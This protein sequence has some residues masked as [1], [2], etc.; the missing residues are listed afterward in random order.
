MNILYEEERGRERESERKKIVKVF[1]FRNAL[2]KEAKDL[3]QVL[4]SVGFVY[5]TMFL[6]P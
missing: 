3:L 1:H 4:V 2:S 6:L 5:R